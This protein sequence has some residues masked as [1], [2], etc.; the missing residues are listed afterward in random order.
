MLRRK[1]KRWQR[2]C[3][4]GRNKVEIAAFEHDGG[5]IV[6]NIVGLDMEVSEHGV[7]APTANKLNGVGVDLAVEKG[8]GTGGS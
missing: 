6:H 3:R 1:L 4:R 5:K 2:S 8:G 7:G